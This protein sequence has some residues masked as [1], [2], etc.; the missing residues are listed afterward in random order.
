MIFQLRPLV[1]LIFLW[2]QLLSYAA[3]AQE[4]PGK[5]N[6]SKVENLGVLIQSA[7]LEHR[8]T[9]YLPRD[10]QTH[11]LLYYV[12]LDYHKVPFQIFDVNLDSRE[13]RTITA[14]PGRPG[15][16]A[17]LLHSNGL[18]YIGSGNP[19][20]FMAYDPE[21]GQSREIKKLADRPGAQY[22][23]EGDD[24][25]VY[26]GECIKGYVER[27]DPKTHAWEN[28]GIIDDPGPPYYRYA[29]TLGADG[30]YVYIAIG[31]NP[32]YLVVYDRVQKKQTVFWK[33][34]KPR[35]V[36]VARGEGG[37]WFA[38]CVSAQGQKAWYRLRGDQPPELLR[39]A[40]KTAPAQVPR[41]HPPGPKYEL[42]LALA[43]PD[44]QGRVKVR[45]RKQ[46]TGAWQEASA[47]MRVSPMDVKRLYA[48]R[49][50]TLLGFTSFYGPVFTY[51]PG[52]RKVEILGRPRRSL[53]DALFHEG[54]WFFVG[55]PAATLRYDPKRSWNLSASTKDLYGPLVNPH[56][57]KVDP[58][59]SAKYHYYLA[60]GADGYIY[61]GGHHER[62]GVGGAL[63]WYH[64]KTR[65]SA[66]LREPFLRYDVSDLIAMDGGHKVIFSSH[67]VDKDIDG[68]I[69]IFDVLQKKLVGDFV[70]LPG[71][72]DAGKLMDVGTGAVIGVVAGTPKS[73]I[74]RADLKQ[75][76]ILWKKE[77]AGRAFGAVRGFD[78]RL[79]KGPDGNIWLYVDNSICRLNPKTSELEKVLEAPPAGNLIFWE[80]DL[81]IYGHPE[82]RKITGLGRDIP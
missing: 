17:T 50:N 55:Y 26:I 24:G 69:F 30:R 68:R 46:G 56:L 67:G 12:N 40:P 63:G 11:S 37:G 36:T 78:R 42:D 47:Q 31:Q 61:F 27:Y 38:S 2:I 13:A 14:V 8:L 51:E 34:L 53:Y 9:F 48:D 23:I 6:P 4:S 18:I 25:A 45:W 57:I 76:K 74:Y 33:D 41:N 77:V 82:L 49:D 7:T 72:R 58:K 10:R 70:P 80:R 1:L 15:P 16:V 43:N 71:G 62:S 75:K 20:Y 66:G 81:Y 3:V 73:F 64:P 28:Y 60:K 39:V 35:N 22:I 29:Y 59:G 5:S 44:A 21:T 19:G 65:V 32:W 52:K 79:V 54:E